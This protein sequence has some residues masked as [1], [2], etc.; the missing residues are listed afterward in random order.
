MPADGPRY[1]VA[2]ASG[3]HEIDE[4]LWTKC[5]PSPLEGRFWYETL[6]TC[7]L[8]DQFT[9]RYALIKS[10][11]DM[12]GIVPCFVHNVPIALVAPRPVAV[13]LSLLSKLFPRAGYQRTFFVGS[14]CSDEGS[15]GLVPGVNLA[16]VA[17]P[18]ARAVRAEARRLKAPMVVFKD[19]SEAGLAALG[20]LCAKEGFFRMI[21][22]PGTVVALPA[23]DKS[24]YLRSLSH[25]QR[26]NFLKKLRRSRE[27]QD[28]ETRVVE[29]PSNREREEIH[30]LFSQTYARGKTKF[31]RLDERFFDR[32]GVQQ[33]ARFIMQRD[34]ASG[35]LLTFMLVF[36]MGERVINKFVGIDY[37]RAGKAFLYFRLFDAALDFAYACGA[38]ELQSGQ[39][40]YRAKL[41]LGH[42]LVPLFNI[43]RHENPLVNA[44]FRAIGSRVTWKTLDSDLATYLRA[45]PIADDVVN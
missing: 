35:E 43:V 26:H 36:I 41:D 10:R 3:F 30:G 42:R 20:G 25:S 17:G 16:D 44:V 22:Y 39:T 40:G 15:I 33:P 32:I 23:P 8:E 2:F 6:E 4:V 27:L 29:T 5:F 45:H 18:L 13:V 11:G 9:F 28:L 1:E 38:R 7:G 21:S 19:F 34:K 31:E 14:P 12:A 37:R 24:A